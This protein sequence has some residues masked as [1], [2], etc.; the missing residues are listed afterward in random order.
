LG[1]AAKAAVPIAACRASPWLISFAG[2][3]TNM[4]RELPHK[5]CD[6]GEPVYSLFIQ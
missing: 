5:D 6:D 3:W 1:I 2:T 4:F